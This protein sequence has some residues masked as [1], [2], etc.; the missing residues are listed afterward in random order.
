[1]ETTL[2]VIVPCRDEAAVVARKLA[3]LARCEWPA[4]QWPHRIVVVDDGSRDATAKL[5][6]EA[7]A[8]FDPARVRV[9]V[10]A[11]AGRP[12]KIGAIAQGL[13]ALVRDADLVV[14]TDA[15]VVV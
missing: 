6:R 8:A 3:N 12:G 10:V 11:N 5:A 2:G 7:A 4:S 13:T 14:L 1:M 9:D 15:D